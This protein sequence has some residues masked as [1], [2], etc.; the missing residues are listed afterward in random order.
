MSANIEETIENNVETI[1]IN[2]DNEE[3]ETME[4]PKV[5]KL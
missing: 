4:K 1:M 3:K 2:E 5:K